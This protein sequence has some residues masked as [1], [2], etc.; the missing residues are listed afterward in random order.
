MIMTIDGSALSRVNSFSGL[1][2]AVVSNYKAAFIQNDKSNNKSVDVTISKEG[3]RLLKN[4][5]INKNLDDA[6][7]KKLET[8]IDEKAI[9]EPRLSRTAD[10]FKYQDEM[11]RIDEP[12]TYAEMY[13][14][15]AEACK[16][17]EEKGWNYDIGELSSD[18]RDEYFKLVGKSM[19]ISQDWYERK[20]MNDGGL[21]NPVEKQYVTLDSLESRYSNTSFNVFSNAYAKIENHTDRASSMWRF[22]TKY[23]VQISNDMLN[24]IV[25]NPDSKKTLEIMK[26]VDDAITK[27]KDL[28]TKYGGEDEYLHFGVKL[29]DDGSVTYRANIFTNTNKSGLVTDTPED[30]LKLIKMLERTD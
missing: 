6:R 28:G 14:Y 20:C 13:K 27:L 1:D 10:P 2:S 22:P 16:L 30:M 3:M 25:N 18:V 4:S 9:V 12:E 11:M 19:S 21:V 23:N 17:L 5:L 29:K 7:K 24:T 15:H 8:V 26:R